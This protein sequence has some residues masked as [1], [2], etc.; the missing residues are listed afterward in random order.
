MNISRAPLLTIL[1]GL[2]LLLY[3]GSV[4]AQTIMRVADVLALEGSEAGAKPRPVQ[5][6]GVVLGV[7]TMF[8]FFALHDGT[9]AV[10]VLR[11]KQR[12]LKQGDLV[13]VAGQTTTTVFSGSSYPRVDADSVSIGGKG[14]LPEAKPITVNSFSFPENYDQWVSLE[15]HV[16]EWSYRAPDLKIALVTGEGYIEAYVTMPDAAALPEGL[17]GAKLRLTGTVVSIPV[18]GRVMFVPGPGQLEVLEPGTSS[19]FE[20]PQASFAD[21]MGRKVEPGKRWRVRGTFAARTQERKIIISGPDGAMTN[22]LLLPRGADDP[23]TLYGDAGPWPELHPGDDVEMV[24]SLVNGSDSDSRCYGLTWCHLRV[25]SEGEAPRPVPMEPDR[26]LN[27]RGRDEW[28]TV[29]AVVVGWTLQNG[30]MLYAL[31]G[32]REGFIL[33]VRESGTATFPKNLHGARLRFTGITRSLLAD[34]GDVMMVPNP[35]LVEIVKPGTGD[36]FDAPE[37][38]TSNI[39]AGKVVPAERVKLRGQVIGRSDETVLYVRGRDGAFCTSLQ[40]PWQRPADA[41]GMFFADGGDWPPIAVGDEVEVIGSPVQQPQGGDQDLFDLEESQ[42]RVL[43]PGRPVR[44]IETSLADVAAGDHTSDLVR[45]RGRLLTL[46]QVPVDRGEWRTTMLLE[47]EGVQLPASFQDRGRASFDTLKVDDEI[48]IQGVVNRATPRDPRQIWLFSAGDVKSFGL[49]PVVRMRQYWYWGGGLLAAFAL[50]SGWIVALRRA[51]RSQVEM[52]SLLEKQV[53]ARTAELE[54]AKSELHR[55]LDQERELNELKSRF[56]TMVSHE[57][58]TPLGIIMSATELMRHYD[59]RLPADQRR[60]LCEDIYSS[61]RLMASLMEQV[62]VLG[63]VEAG[64]L[65]CRRAPCDIDVL[66]GKLVDEVHSATN[67]RCTAHWTAKNDLSGALADESILRH[68]LTNLLTN[69]IKYSPE[70]RSVEITGERVGGDV[71]F[72]VIDHGIGIPPAD[73]QRLFEAFHRGN[74]VGEIP[75]TGLGLVIV[76][77]CVDLHD[78]VIEVDSELNRGTTFTVRVPVFPV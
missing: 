76:K 68:I 60:E 8:N 47:S 65:G 74:N 49:S 18:P 71:V 41:K 24:G 28:A 50:L 66:V 59:E 40:R 5:L 7:S 25:I 55:S 3:G 33:N 1:L 42:L 34:P 72:Q 14:D 26:L 44:A 31:R 56:V 64:K 38:S 58:R 53:S 77:R 37:V 63:R 32:P 48:M 12:D 11:R 15:G 22:Y 9:G 21:V 2:A 23:D 17:H 62:L 73:Q 35:G 67:R 30:T 69:A 78:G 57:F 52:A 45:V 51:N 43:Q 20:A 13:E 6:K 4:R 29:E 70:G 54:K 10:G 75:G 46:Q 36:P 39:V 27:L 16:M 19:I 61:T